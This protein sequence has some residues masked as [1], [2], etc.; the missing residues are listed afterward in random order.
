MG[1]GVV[2]LLLALGYALLNGPNEQQPDTAP[3]LPVAHM[4]STTPT[5]TTSTA[6]PVVVSVV[7]H[8]SDP[9]VFT[10]SAGA[11]VADALEEAGGVN[12][13]AD[14]RSVNL[15]R[16]VVDGEQLYVGVSAPATA[17]QPPEAGRQ[18]GESTDTINL[19]TADLATLQE[20]PRVGEVTAQ[21]IIDWRQEHDGFETVEQLRQVTGIG[22]KTLA[23]LRDQVRLE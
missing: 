3:R 7:G 4:S 10:L 16:R 9:G 12:A 18:A 19:N 22:A 13:A 17:S 1:I 11:R 6:G 15:A 14:R 5:T 20:L 2:A 23:D 8:V 21:R